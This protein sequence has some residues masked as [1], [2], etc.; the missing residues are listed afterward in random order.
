MAF[1]DTR[2][3]SNAWMPSLWSVGARF[4]ITGCSRITSSSTSQTSGL[5]RSTI[6]FA[7]FMVVQ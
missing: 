7:L 2:T 1:P 5:S 6:F 3:G 4:S